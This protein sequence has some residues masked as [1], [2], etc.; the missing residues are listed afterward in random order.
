MPNYVTNRLEIQ[1]KPA[2]IKKV[3]KFLAPVSKSKEL[4]HYDSVITF[5]K[6]TPTPPWVYQG[7]LGPEEKK[8]YGDENCWL[9]WNRANW[10]TKWD[11]CESRIED[12]N[13]VFFLTAWSA[14]PD[15]M[16][17]LGLIFPEVKFIY[18]WADE[19]LGS[20]TGWVVFKG[21]EVTESCVPKNHTKEAYELAFELLK[22][23]PEDYDLF[24]SEEA[25]TYVFK[26]EEESLEF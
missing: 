15:L 20:N 19:D 9:H 21:T 8:K 1:G 13:V 12:G 24:Y 5:E 26:E 14:V 3:L 6:I 18:K 11:A 17:K 25:G 23:K 10:G 16:L 4:S 2:E 22:E 7:D